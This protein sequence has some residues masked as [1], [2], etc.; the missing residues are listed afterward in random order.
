MTVIQVSRFGVLSNTQRIDYF[1]ALRKVRV[2]S[3]CFDV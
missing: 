1:W 2:K 3:V